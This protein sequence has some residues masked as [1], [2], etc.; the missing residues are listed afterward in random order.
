MKVTLTLGANRFDVEGEFTFDAGFLNVVRLWMNAQQ[1]G[2]DAEMLEALT[3][4][5]KQAND[6]AEAV[7]TANTPTFEGE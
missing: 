6:T 2:A 1:P 4:R 3:D 5:L 7:I